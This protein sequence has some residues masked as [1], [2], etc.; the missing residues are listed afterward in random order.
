MAGGDVDGAV[1]A[2]RRRSASTFEAPEMARDAVD[3]AGP[4]RRRGEAAGRER[5]VRT[6]VAIER[7][8]GCSKATSGRG[9]QSCRRAY[10]PRSAAVPSEASQKSLPDS[11]PKAIPPAP[12]AGEALTSS[13]ASTRP[14]SPVEGEGAARIGGR[15]PKRAG[16]HGCRR[17]QRRRFRRDRPRGSS[18]RPMR[19]RP[20]SRSGVPSARGK[21]TVPSRR[22]R[23]P[24]IALLPRVNEP[25][26]ASAIVSSFAVPPE[27]RPVERRR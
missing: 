1:G 19:S 8:A 11:S 4:R 22:K 24:L 26:L 6:P 7:E 18:G 5:R 16:G 27:V 12:R 15:R 13:A 9:E 2:D 25:L 10:G 23:P 17:R 3:W 14:I 21:P 20:G